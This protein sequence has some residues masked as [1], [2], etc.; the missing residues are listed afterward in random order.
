M[1]K[2][3]GPAAELTSSVVYPL[4]TVKTRLQALPSDERPGSAE[5]EPHGAKRH[6]SALHARLLR[7]LRRWEMLQML[8]RIVKTEGLAGV[9]K[10]FSAN[11][12]NTFS[13]RE[14]ELTSHVHGGV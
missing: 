1:R 9:F 3:L 2:L 8:L 6:G 10:G 5:A 4:D 7:R 14:S 11:M 13:Q 12:I